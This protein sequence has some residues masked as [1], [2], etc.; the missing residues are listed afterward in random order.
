MQ[1]SLRQIYRRS[2][3]GDEIRK[4]VRQNGCLLLTAVILIVITVTAVFIVQLLQLVRSQAVMSPSLLP[5]AVSNEGHGALLLR[6]VDGSPRLLGFSGLGRDLAPEAA[7]LG[8]SSLFGASCTDASHTPSADPAEEKNGQQVRTAQWRLS[9]ELSIALDGPRRSALDLAGSSVLPEVQ[10]TVRFLPRIALIIDDWGYNWAM[11]ERF[12]SLDLP[13]T[14]AVLPGREKTREQAELLR[15]RGH[16][17]ILHL[18]MEPLDPEIE[19]DDGFITTDLDDA[20][21]RRRVEEA[22]ASV[23]EVAGVNNHMGSKATSDE[24]VVR[25]VLEVVRERGLYF[26]DSRTS[27]GSVAGRIA[28]EMGIPTAVNQMF[29]DHESD[30]EKVKAQIER[31]IRRAKRDGQALGIGHVR[32]QTYRALVEMIPRFQEEGV[33]VVPASR[34]VSASSHPQD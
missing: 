26:V 4:V 6:P 27:P 29:L 23:G 25:V 9:G 8:T 3:A 30:V 7:V 33:V 22:L 14:A 15:Q 2:R 34:L 13:F 1:L 31:L 21:I 24:R 19:L 11:A 32:P 28:G 20:D 17:V 16:E 18:P 5:A 10:L 12:L